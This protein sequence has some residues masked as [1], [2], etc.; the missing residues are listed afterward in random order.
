MAVSGLGLFYATTGGVLL[1]SG[2]KGQTIK[3]TITA[4][5]SGNAAALAQKG[6]Q[7]V[8]SPVVGSS[9]AAAAQDVQTGSGITGSEDNPAAASGVSTVT[10]AANKAAGVLV[11]A[12]FGW[13]GSQ[14]TDLDNIV[15]AESGW[16]NLIQNPSSGAFGIA[17]ALGHGTAGTAGKYGNNYGAN[18]GLST[19]SAIAANNGSAGPQIT[20]LCGYIK[21]AYGTPAAAWAFHLANGY[22]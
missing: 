13:A 20:W 3:E 4:I 11:A 8:G 2:F 22:Y 21:A 19:A 9:T 12:S 7:A 16:N 10:E 18:Y 14:F 1:W 6:S 17:Q 15:M 5:T